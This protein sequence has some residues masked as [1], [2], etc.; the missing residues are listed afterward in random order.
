MVSK[1]PMTSCC[2]ISQN[3]V[4]LKEYGKRV[5]LTAL[6]VTRKKHIFEPHGQ[7]VYLESLES[8]QIIFH[9]RVEKRTI[10]REGSN[11][12]SCSTLL[13]CALG[14]LQRFFVKLSNYIQ[15][16]ITV[17]VL[18]VIIASFWIYIFHQ[19]LAS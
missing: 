18:R 12:G 19:H 1:L 9:Q 6:W 8:I 3:S 16:E 13:G 5:W 2:N 7:A 14:I 15:I 11:G 17:L 4:F 10:V